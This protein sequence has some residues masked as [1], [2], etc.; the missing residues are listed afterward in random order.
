[1]F[2]NGSDERSIR[3]HTTHPT[4]PTPV[5]ARALSRTRASHPDVYFGWTSLSKRK[6][7]GKEMFVLSDW[8]EIELQ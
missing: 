3:E 1:M 7:T 4:S 2:D 8:Q 6:L 5:N